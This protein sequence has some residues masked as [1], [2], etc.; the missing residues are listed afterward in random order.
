MRSL[1][2]VFLSLFCIVCGVKDHHKTDL[3]LQALGYTN[4]FQF[5]A[6]MPDICELERLSSEDYTWSVFAKE[7]KKIG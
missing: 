2:R 7:G 6:Q 3:P 5:L 1:F 4:V